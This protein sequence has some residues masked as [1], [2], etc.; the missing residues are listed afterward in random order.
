MISEP[1]ATPLLRGTLE[2]EVQYPSRSVSFKMV[3]SPRENPASHRP[4]GSATLNSKIVMGDD[5]NNREV[6]RRDDRLLTLPDIRPST[7]AV[8]LVKFS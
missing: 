2:T 7:W 3:S 5:S 8:A 4:G 1:D 6:V